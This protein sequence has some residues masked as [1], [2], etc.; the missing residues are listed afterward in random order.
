M[1]LLLS[2]ANETRSFLQILQ[3]E[4]IGLVASAFILVSFFFSKQMLI[5][6]VNLCGCVVFVIY[7]ILLPSYSTA[8]M[9][10]ALIIVHV[11][12]LVRGIVAKKK[13]KKT[14]DANI[15]EAQNN[16]ASTNTAPNDVAPTNTAP[17]NAAPNTAAPNN[18]APN[19]TAPSDVIQNSAD[20]TNT[21][22]QK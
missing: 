14:D 21:D 4:W 17:N 22:L 10:L 15:A 9:N 20:T 12:F 19:T 3:D 13:A 6:I 18:A 7:G 11:V 16:D 8:I 2:I 5:R 1:N